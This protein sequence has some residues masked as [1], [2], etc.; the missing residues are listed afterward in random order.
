MRPSAMNNKCIY[1]FPI[2]NRDLFTYL[3][4][5]KYTVPQ[6]LARPYRNSRPQPATT[7][8]VLNDTLLPSPQTG[9]RLK[10]KHVPLMQNIQSLARKSDSAP[11]HPYQCF[12]KAVGINGFIY[13]RFDI[14]R[15]ELFLHLWRRGGR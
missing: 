1:L 6:K 2:T 15:I 12:K 7:E 5:R 9:S 4:R 8:N 14:Q 11:Y 13:K 10:W 3:W